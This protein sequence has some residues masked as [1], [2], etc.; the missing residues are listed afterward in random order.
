VQLIGLTGGIASGKST[1]ASRL[2]S[3]GAVGVDA[4]RIARE[5]VEPGTPALAAIERSFGPDVIAADGTLDRPALGAIVFGDREALQVLNGITHPAVLAESTARFR[6]AAAADPDAIVIY[7]VPL[8]VESANEYPFDRIVVAHADAATRIQ[9]LVTLRGMDAAEAE[10]RIHSQASDDERLAVADV[11]IETG[12]T[13][14]HTLEQVDALWE[15]LR[16]GS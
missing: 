12:G 1:I 8:L 14:A 13:L 5:V 7:D 16:G 9:R 3:H 4:D 11:V 6:A 10:R 15:E 2:A